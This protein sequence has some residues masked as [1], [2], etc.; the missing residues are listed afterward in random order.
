MKLSSGKLQLWECKSLLLS[1]AYAGI[2]HSFMPEMSEEGLMFYI[3]CVF[4]T[5]YIVTVIHVKNGKLL[6]VASWES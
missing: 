4:V 5:G 1:L 2:L 6:I 3:L